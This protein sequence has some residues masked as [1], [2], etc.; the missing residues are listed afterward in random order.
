[1]AAYHPIYLATSKLEEEELS[2][3]MEILLSRYLYLDDDE[4]DVNIYIK[5]VG[6]AI[7]VRPVM[8]RLE[9]ISLSSGGTSIPASFNADMV[10][11][12]IDGTVYRIYFRPEENPVEA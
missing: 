11:F 2:R 9:S 3:H 6:D 8:G 1:M 5:K 12:G 4:E 10:E 7:E